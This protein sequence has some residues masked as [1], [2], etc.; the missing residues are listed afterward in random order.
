MDPRLLINAIVQQTMVFIA[1]LATAGGVRAPLVHVADRVFR[2]LTR[3]LLSQGLKKKVIADMF[4]LELRTYQRRLQA[5]EQSRTDQGRTVWEAVLEYLREHEPVSGARVQQRFQHDVPEIVAG[6]LNDFVNSWLA[7]RAGRG[8]QAVY[9]IA[10]A[11]D[12]Q[13]EAARERAMDLVVWLSVYRDGPLDSERV[14]EHTGLAGDVV[15][16]SLDRLL[17]E[18]RIQRGA[19]GSY[20][21]RVFEKPWDVALGW[22]AAVL[23]HFR[24][25]VTTITTKLHSGGPPGLEDSVGGSTWTLD[26]WPGHPFQTEALGVLGELRRRVEGLRERIDR[27]NAAAARPDTMQNVVVYLGQHV[28]TT[29]A[30]EKP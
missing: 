15:A 28:R 9:R 10:Q 19:D 11:T 1:Q 12:F 14:T 5:A 29:D 30:E 13:D 26:V 18:D 8:E 7:Y 16:E 21:S 20:S 3:E 25:M 24:A 23:D 6:V 17:G 4:G 2:E 22:E 27:F